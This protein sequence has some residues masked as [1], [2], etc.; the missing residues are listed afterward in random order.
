MAELDYFTCRCNPSEFVKTISVMLFFSCYGGLGRS[1]LGKLF[2][3]IP[4]K[5]ANYY[6]H[7]LLP[8]IVLYSLQS[9]IYKMMDLASSLPLF[10]FSVAVSLLMILDEDLD[11]EAAIEKIRGLKGPGAIQSVKVG[12]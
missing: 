10:L 2:T 7:M 5:Q 1:G 12:P 4:S 8:C 6:F 3:C 11:T 9:T